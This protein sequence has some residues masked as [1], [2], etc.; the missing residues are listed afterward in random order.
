MSHASHF[1]TFKEAR[2]Y[3]K[4]NLRRS[5]NLFD[6][7]IC[8]DDVK[9]TWYGGRIVYIRRFN[10]NSVRLYSSLVLALRTEGPPNMYIESYKV[11]LKEKED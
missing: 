6:D 11:K 7:M 3:L 4:K 9:Q 1:D 5:V 2:E 10:L 8:R